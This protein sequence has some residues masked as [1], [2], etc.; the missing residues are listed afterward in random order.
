MLKVPAVFSDHCV[1]QREKNVTLWGESTD[2]LVTVSL[3]G[4]DGKVLVEAT[5]AVG[6]DGKWQCEFPAREAGG[7]YELRV[8]SG[9]EMRTYADVYVGEVWLAGGQSNM[10]FPLEKAL[11]AAE[12]LKEAHAAYVVGQKKDAAAAT[13]SPSEGAS[14][15]TD[16]IS[17]IRFYQTPRVS[18]LGEELDAAEA[19]NAWQVYGQ[20]GMEGWSAVATYFAQKVAGE[21]DCMVGIIGCNWGGT[22]ASCWTSRQKLSQL[23]ETNVYNIEYDRATEGQVEEKYLKELAHYKEYQAVF[24]R[25]V[26]HYYETAEN[27]TWEEALSLY[28]QNLYPGPMGPRNERRPGGLYEAMLGRVTPYT[29]R[30]FLYYQAEE[31]DH[32]PYNY[33]K[34]FKALIEQWRAD[35]KEESL[36]FLY[37]MLPMFTDA[38]AEDFKNWAFLREAQMDVSRSVQGAYMASALEYGEYGNIHPTN[39]QPVGERLANQALAHVYGREE[40]KEECY[41]PFLQASR[42]DGTRVLL[43]FAADEM[44]KL[45]EEALN[46]AGFEIAGRDGRYVAAEVSILTNVSDAAG[47]STTADT[48]TQKEAERVITLALSSPEVPQPAYAR[49]LWTNYHEVLLYGRNGIPVNPF[50]TSRDDG[51]K[52]TGSRNGLVKELLEV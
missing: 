39:K 15:Q 6:A 34:L 41:G 46:K 31:D 2:A 17:Q 48:G 35:W 23:K 51:A 11:G 18:Y 9:E 8:S 36:P 7:P 19:A 44:T 32:R 1:L 50:R 20:E 28:G 25:N 5:A 3:L 26:S 4:Q 30:G 27:P 10:E 24:D 12:L 47:D 14:N 52:A 49:Y 13:N 38:G 16:A 21:L 42:I 22:S 40:Y 29:L 43:D 33:E 37:V 45:S